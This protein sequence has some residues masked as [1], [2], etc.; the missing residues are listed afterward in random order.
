MKPKKKLQPEVIEDVEA[1]ITLKPK[2]KPEQED[3]EEQ[4][5]LPK[6]KKKMVVEEAADEM[7]IKKEVEAYTK[8]QF[9]TA[10]F[11]LHTTFRN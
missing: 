5:K 11:F 6:K 8:N 3:V 9:Y 10:Y 2:K 4:I 1:E 7:T